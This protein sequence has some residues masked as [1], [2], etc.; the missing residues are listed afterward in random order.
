MR[1]SILTVLPF[2]AALLAAAPVAA[3]D[4][5][6]H[7]RDWLDCEKIRDSS[8]RHCSTAEAEWKAT[9]HP[10]VVDSSPNGGVVVV[11]WDRNIV[12]VRAVIHARGRDK[13]AADRLAK[14]IDV[15]MAAARITATG[16]QTDAWSVT[17]I[18]HVP[19]HSDLD[20][21]A[22]NGP[23]EVEGV[24]GSM[25]LATKNGP[26]S[27]ED[28]G[29]DVR[30]QSTNGPLNV[31]LAGREWSGK[32]LVAETQN[33]PVHLSIPDRYSAV[34]T[35]GTRNGPVDIAL[36]VRVR[37]GSYFTTELGSGGK[38]LRIV[39]RNGPISIRRI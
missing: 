1:R 18:V 28:V 24:T 34:L 35:S 3:H 20:L 37:D 19:K 32:G 13:S 8:L 26:I 14:E 17:F 9:G 21:R 22:Y 29:G 39:T 11:G 5:D 10:I 27:I 38:A 23:V 6:H 4:G 16:P 30:A 7:W 31:R 33:G 12:Q 36:P 25:T 15:T 2:A